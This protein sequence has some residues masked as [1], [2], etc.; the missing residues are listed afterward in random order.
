MTAQ[1]RL[2]LFALVGAAL[3]TACDGG[4]SAPECRVYL[5]EEAP[6]SFT[7]IHIVASPAG[8]NGNWGPNLINDYEELSSHPYLMYRLEPGT[9]DIRA[10]MA[11][12][13]WGGDG[14]YE[15]LGVNLGDH[16]G[17][18]YTAGSDGYFFTTSFTFD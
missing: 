10:V 3:W 4:A 15:K 9:Y 5:A 16:E 6:N 12:D 1:L 2:V 18:K 13:A 7:E 8:E 11:N 14:A 17:V